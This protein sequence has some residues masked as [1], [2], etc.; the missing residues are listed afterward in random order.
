MFYKK[1]GIT[2]L[3]VAISLMLTACGI[4]PFQAALRKLYP[5]EET[6]SEGLV[7]PSGT[8]NDSAE[9]NSSPPRGTSHGESLPLSLFQAEDGDSVWQDGSLLCSTEWNY[10]YLSQEDAAVYPALVAALDVLNQETA[11][12]GAAYTTELSETARENFQVKSADDL[13]AWYSQESIVR[14]ADQTALSFLHYEEYFDTVNYGSIVWAT[15]LD[16]ATGKKLTLAD[17]FVHPEEL[18]ELLDDQ[19]R[20]NGQSVDE[21]TKEYF[22]SCISREEFF[23]V[24]GYQNVTFYFSPPFDSLYTDDLLTLSFWFQDSPHL[25][26]EKFRS[27]PC[28]Y[29]VKLDP[30]SPLDID[31][32]RDDDFKDTIRY[33]SYTGWPEIWVNDQF[34]SIL[35]DEEIDAGIPLRALE[36]YFVHTADEHHLLY[37]DTAVWNDYH[38]LSIYSLDDACLLE[39]YWSVGFYEEFTEE[40]ER[41]RELFTDPADFTLYALTELLGTMWGV[42]KYQVDPSSGLAVEKNPYFDV[43]NDNTLTA[44]IPLEAIALPDEIHETIPAGTNLYFLRTDCLSYVDMQAEDGREWRIYVDASQWP[45]TVNNVSI[46]QC[47]DGMFYSG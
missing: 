12:A 15:N 2:L 21:D 44:L 13:Y 5:P 16:P 42:C 29:V 35:P 43:I 24:V 17:V 39:R 22:A 26:Q 19:Y 9:H 4:L 28:Q 31:L 47:F 14:R 41:R 40:G 34:Y 38:V 36:V 20:A 10:F 23:W 18:P 11:A 45:I 6:T 33:E 3:A 7:P 25:F 32:N 27:P 30:H 37:I 46:D 8:V 1:M